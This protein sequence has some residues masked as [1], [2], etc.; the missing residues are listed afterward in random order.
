[1]VEQGCTGRGCA[2]AAGAICL[3]DFTEGIRVAIIAGIADL[4]GDGVIIIAILT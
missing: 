3:N 2:A 4:G 1:M